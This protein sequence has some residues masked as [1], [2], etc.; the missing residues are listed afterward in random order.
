M[1][2]I[3][4]FYEYQGE[5]AFRDSSRNLFIWKKKQVKKKMLKDKKKDKAV[6]PD[7]MSAS[8]GGKT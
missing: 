4:I 6:L 1:T 7:T 2:Y 3:N 8:F 5:Y